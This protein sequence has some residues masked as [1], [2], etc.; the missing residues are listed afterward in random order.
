MLIQ[1]T[2]QA[3]ITLEQIRIFVIVAQHGGVR[4]AAA[5]LHK[6]Q[7]ALTHALRNMESSLGV[8]LFDRTKYRLE[9]TKSGELILEK[10]LEL[11]AQYK[12]FE[13]MAGSLSTHYESVLT[14]AYDSV[15]DIHQF[16]RVLS[17]CQLN[18]P[19]TQIKL[20][21]ENLSGPFD[22]LKEDCNALVIS[23]WGSFFKELPDSDLHTPLTS[24]NFGEVEM[25]AVIASSKDRPN[26]RSIGDLKEEFQVVISNSSQLSHHRTWGIAR[27]DRCYYVND[28]AEKKNLIMSGL[29]W[30]RLP[31]HLIQQ[32]LEAGKI[33]AL[34]LPDY[35]CRRR[36]PLSIY[37]HK[38]CRTGPV[39]DCIWDSL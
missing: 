27:N 31:A 32:E 5:V 20:I 15:F 9:L 37:R 19:K 30:G 18:F 11:M 8:S 17:L 13:L 22:I 36:F 28:Y 2:Y 26:I 29:G 35:E 14:I 16:K 25:I 24:K 4:A 12:E 21:K 3:V 39:M 6:S 10:A 38:D 34:D 33:V 7:P 1:G 23:P